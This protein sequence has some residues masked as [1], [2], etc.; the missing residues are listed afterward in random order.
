MNGMA[1]GN[2]HAYRGLAVLEGWLAAGGDNFACRRLAGVKLRLRGVALGCRGCLLADKGFLFHSHCG[3]S[4]FYLTALRHTI[5]QAERQSP[6]DHAA[7]FKSLKTRG[8]M[9]AVSP[10]TPP[11]LPPGPM[12]GLNFNPLRLNN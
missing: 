11:Q 8:K 3:F 1:G 10:V 12:D 9:K 2:N 5:V 7:N 6:R 4:R